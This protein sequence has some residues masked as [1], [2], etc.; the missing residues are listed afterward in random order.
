VSIVARARWTFAVTGPC[1]ADELAECA[2]GVMEALLELERCDG[3][4]L[5]S[6][7]AMDADE[8]TV[9]VEVTVQAASYPQIVE[10]SMGIV[11]TAIHAAGHGTPGWPGSAGTGTPTRSSVSVVGS[12][13][14]QRFSVNV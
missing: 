7:V 13:T 14:R 9:V 6:G 2:Q 11:R 5:D 4:L 3:D 10:R 8:K 12:F 1:N